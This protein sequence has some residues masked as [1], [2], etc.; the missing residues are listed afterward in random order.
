MR[1][2]YRTNIFISILWLCS[3]F[4][5]SDYVVFSNHNL[6]CVHNY[7]EKES[8][9]IRQKIIINIRKCEKKKKE[10]KR[11]SYEKGGKVDRIPKKK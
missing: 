4:Q 8:I 5:P 2:G 1:R 3:I 11:M 10:T 7:P 9:L 6:Y